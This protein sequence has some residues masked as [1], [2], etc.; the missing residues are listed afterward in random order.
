MNAHRAVD[1]GIT[2]G[3]GFD[4]G[5]VFRADAD[6]QEVPYPTLARSFKGGV[7]GAAVLG[8]VEAIKV[9]MGIYEHRDLQLESRKVSGQRY[10]RRPLKLTAAEQTDP[11]HQQGLKQQHAI[12]VGL[13]E[14]L[15][16]LG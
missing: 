7:E 16:A 10:T 1:I 5:G 8:Q 2:I 6:A 12:E 3:Q 14:D 4:V 9:A 13:A 15:L 11:L